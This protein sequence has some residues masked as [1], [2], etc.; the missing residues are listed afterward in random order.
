MQKYLKFLI[1]IS[2]SDFISF[3]YTNSFFSKFKVKSNIVLLQMKKKIFCSHKKKVICIKSVNFKFLEILR[4]VIQFTP[5][6]IVIHAIYF[7]EFYCFYNQFRSIKN[8]AL[9]KNSCRTIF[10]PFCDIVNFCVSAVNLIFYYFRE[11]LL[12]LL[13]LLVWIVD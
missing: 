4:H 9:W 3:L 12:M 11:I 13:W 1:Y 10:F 7:C 5:H 6:F 2:I 8:L